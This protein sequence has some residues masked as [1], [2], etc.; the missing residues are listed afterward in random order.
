MPLGREVGL[1][2]GHVVLDGDPAPLPKG[3]HLPNFGSMSIVTKRS[4]SQLLLST[5]TNGR[6]KT[7]WLYCVECL[8][9]SI[10]L[11]ALGCLCVDVCLNA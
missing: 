5:C 2:P 9:Y 3:A 6:P 11:E 4:P 10:R 1:S 7:R 8:Q